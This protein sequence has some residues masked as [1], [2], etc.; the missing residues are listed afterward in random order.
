MNFTVL[1]LITFC[2]HNCRFAFRRRWYSF[3]QEQASTVLSQNVCKWDISCSVRCSVVSTFG[4]GFR[5]MYVQ[6]IVQ[7]NIQV[8]TGDMLRAR[9]SHSSTSVGDQFFFVA[10]MTPHTV[11]LSDVSYRFLLY[12]VQI[13]RVTHCSFRFILSMTILACVLG[14][15]LLLVLSMGTFL[16]LTWKTLDT[17]LSSNS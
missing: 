9:R 1:L 14:L 5:R 10:W 17:K 11:G 7:N 15:F 2:A 13:W 16:C 8:H 4:Y 6:P 12:I 3:A